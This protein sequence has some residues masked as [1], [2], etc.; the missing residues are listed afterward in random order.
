MDGFQRC[1]D[2]L[3]ALRLILSHHATS[4]AGVEKAREVADMLEASANGLQGS[5]Y[6]RNLVRKVAAAIRPSLFHWSIAPGASV[7]A[8]CTPA[9]PAACGRRQR[10]RPTITT[11]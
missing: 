5:L 8:A 7:N 10:K 4:E 11:R 6:Q 9:L 2:A 3:G 1:M